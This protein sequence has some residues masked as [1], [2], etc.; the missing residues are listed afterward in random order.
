MDSEALGFLPR[1][2]ELS[3][4]DGEALTSHRE[5]IV[6]TAG[7]PLSRQSLAHQS[8][9][10][11]MAGPTLSQESRGRAMCGPRSDPLQE[12]VLGVRAA[13]AQRASTS[14]QLH[15]AQR[16]NRFFLKPSEQ[17]MSTTSY[18]LPCFNSRIH[19]NQLQT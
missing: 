12:R 16:E 1:L 6:G 13:G 17:Q 10:Q 18:N 9:L 4:A 19:L 15:V 3:R 8:G 7:E 14:G 11:R 2:W 5:Q